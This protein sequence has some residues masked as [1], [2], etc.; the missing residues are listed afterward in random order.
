MTQLATAPTTRSRQWTSEDVGNIISLEHVNTTIPDQTPAIAFY[1]MGMGF[2]RDPYLNVGLQN[3][4]ANIGEEQIHMPTR[5]AQ[6]LPGH[7][8]IVVPSLDALQGRLESV[9]DLLKDT[10][11]AY[12]VED[13]YVKAISPWGN[14][15]RAYEP[16]P[17]FGDIRIGIPYVDVKVRPGTAEG[18][19]RF[20]QQV[21][22]APATVEQNGG[23]VTHVKIGTRQELIF[24]E[25]D[26]KIPPYDKHHIAIYIA[27]FSGPYSFLQERGLVTEEVRNSQ[28]RFQEIVDPESG[29]QLHTLEHEV[30][31]LHHRMY[32]R[33]MVNRNA[34]QNMMAYVRGG[35]VLNP[36]G[37]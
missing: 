33:H 36:Y 16:D 28:C 10:K 7:V 31:S 18:I 15:F 27:D 13:G 9:K 32:R 11:F 24:R 30:R 4:W 2:T 34:E 20:Y 25:T 21:M 12:S 19:A 5:G 6:V 22:G 14:E 8:G 23:P 3:F 29:E 1:I 35:D 37:E 17:R 26:E